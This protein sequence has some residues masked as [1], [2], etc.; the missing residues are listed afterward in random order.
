MS[1]AKENQL[2]V[3]ILNPN[4]TSFPDPSDISDEPEPT[5][6]RS[7]YL[8][9]EP[10]PRRL[11]KKIEG[12]A[13][14][15]EHI[16]YVYDQIISTRCPAKKLYVVAHSAGGD[17][18]MFL[19]RKRSDE[20]FK[21]LTK[22]AFTDSVH[23]ILPVESNEVRSFLRGHAIHFVASDRPMGEPIDC[24]YDFSQ[25]A[26]CEEVSAGHSKHEYTSGY[27]VDGVFRFFFP[28]K[29]NDEENFEAKIF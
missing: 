9:S 14:N 18:L 29:E 3:I 4:Q 21:K 11:S 20:I 7:F 27:C 16:L 13:T 15:R 26:A 22:I 12:L 1:K 28:T 24:D 17:G 10:L 25:R 8:S 6:I 5:D 19:L 2:S 23:S